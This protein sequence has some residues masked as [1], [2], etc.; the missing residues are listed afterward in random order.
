MYEVVQKRLSGPWLNATVCASQP[1]TS[2]FWHCAR[3]NAFG[4][5]FVTDAPGPGGDAQQ[6][7]ANEGKWGQI[8]VCQSLRDGSQRQSTTANDSQ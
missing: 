5:C 7:A 3:G 6:M 2:A 4:H 8:L 1:S